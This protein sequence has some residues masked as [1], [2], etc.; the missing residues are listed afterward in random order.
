MVVVLA[1]IQR[2]IILD[3]DLGFLAHVRDP[4]G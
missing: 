4:C 2:M 3:S 1:G